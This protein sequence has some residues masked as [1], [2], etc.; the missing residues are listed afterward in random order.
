MGEFDFSIREFNLEEDLESVLNFDERFSK[1]RADKFQRVELLDSYFS[2]VAE[3][4]GDIV[5]FIV[6]E[7][8][9]DGISYYL[10][11]VDVSEK[12]RRLGIGTA[13]IDNVFDIVGAEKRVTLNVN[14]DN[15]AA[16]AFYERL[17]FERCGETRNYR[18]GQNKKWY[19]KKISL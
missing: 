12:Y 4:D 15:L 17:G 7:D 3:K 8:L 19:T 14:E 11:Q 10:V 5:G 1:R 13:L 18:E 9:S 6:M 2:L 16:I